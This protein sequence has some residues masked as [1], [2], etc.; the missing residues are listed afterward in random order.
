MEVAWGIAESKLDGV[1]GR[2]V[3]V[4][5]GRE[6]EGEVAVAVVR[7]VVEIDEAGRVEDEPRGWVEIEEDVG[8]VPD[9][10]DDDDDDEGEDDEGTT[11]EESEVTPER[12]R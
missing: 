11:N 4:E 6:E 9:D 3:V 12:F 5:R 10:D 1:E 7:W 8:C 2:P